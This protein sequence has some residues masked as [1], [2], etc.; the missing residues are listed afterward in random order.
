MAGSDSESVQAGLTW[1]VRGA[2]LV[3]T[4]ECYR[5]EGGVGRYRRLYDTILHPVTAY[6]V[7]AWWTLSTGHEA[8]SE[9]PPGSW[10]PEGGVPAALCAGRL[11]LH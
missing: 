3:Q 7:R 4:L 5:T 1:L 2:V 10:W 6:V 11:P 9:P 8:D